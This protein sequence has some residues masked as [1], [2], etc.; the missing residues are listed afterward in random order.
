MTALDSVSQYRT[1]AHTCIFKMGEST[2]TLKIYNLSQ[3]CISKTVFSFSQLE[4]APNVQFSLSDPSMLLETMRRKKLIPSE[5]F[6]S[7]EECLKDIERI[8][9]QVKPTIPFESKEFKC[10]LTLDVFSE[11]V[12]DEHGHTFEKGAIEQQLKIK[13]ECPINR[14]PIDSLTPNLDIQQFIEEKKQSPIP[15]FALF[16]RQNTKLTTSSLKLAQDCID[17]EEYEQALNAYAIA[18]QYTKNWSDYRQLPILFERMQQKEKALLAYLYLIQYQLQDK[19]VEEALKTVEQGAFAKEHPKEAII[20]YR[21]ILTEDPYQF[22]IYPLLA[23]LL[24]SP[25]EKA[26]ILLKGACHALQKKE[27][28]LVHDFCSQAENLYEDSFIDRLI[29][30]GL[31]SKQEAKEKLIQVAALYEKKNLPTLMIKAYRMLTQ[32]GYSPSYYKLRQVAMSLNKLGNTCNVRKHYDKAIKFHKQAL[33]IGEKISNHAGIAV[34]LSNLGSIYDIQ[35]QYDKAIESYE[36]ALKA[37]EKIITVTKNAGKDHLFLP[38]VAICLGNLGSAHKAQEQY[39]KAINFFK[40]ALEVTEEA[41][42]KDH[43]KVANLLNNL[44][45]IY[46]IQGLHDKAA[47]L[48]K[49]EREIRE[50]LG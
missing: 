8:I 31:L 29:H 28:Q 46:D 2:L 32:L 3:E 1:W 24:S 16:K 33:E 18:F 36:R 42:G 35:G 34:S 41:L 45:S 4:I 49:R 30:L 50:K 38:F 5:S 10:P 7:T 21:Q 23:S 48:Y 12:I 11:P 47:E 20:V 37:E 25:C 17:A 14:Q 39:D 26:H 9:T 27:H 43:P 44:G 15:T 13:N 40:Q 22:K 19:K 6:L